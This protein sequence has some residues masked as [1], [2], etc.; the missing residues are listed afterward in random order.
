MPTAHTRLTMCTQRMTELNWSNVFGFRRLGEP[1]IMRRSSPAPTPAQM[2]IPTCGPYPKPRCA[3]PVQAPLPSMCPPPPPANSSLPGSPSLCCSSLPPELLT[4]GHHSPAA[5]FMMF[6]CS[7]S[8]LW[9]RDAPRTTRGPC[10]REAPRHAHGAFRDHANS[11][12]H[13]KPA[14][15]LQNICSHHQLFLLFRDKEDKEVKSSCLYTEKLKTMLPPRC[16]QDGPA[17]G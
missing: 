17:A 6:S 10:S 2:W 12:P 5:P 14:T 1:R 8:S 15:N 7:G 3:T 13:H 11:L 4:A 9:K 16:W